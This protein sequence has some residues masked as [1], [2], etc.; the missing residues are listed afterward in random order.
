VEYPVAVA[1]AESV[2]HLPR[3]T[4]WW[5]EPKFD[6]DRGVLW[7]RDTVRIQTRAGRDATEQWYDIAAAA[8]TLPP[9]TV[10]DGELVIWRDGRIDFGAVRSRASARG[11]RLTDLIQRQPATYAAFDCLMLGGRDL[12]G[13]SYLDRRAA[14]LEVLDPLGPPLQA[15]PATD[16]IDV[17][18]AWHEHLPAQGIEG[19]VAKAATGTYRPTRDWKKIRHA[20]TVDAEVIGYVGPAERPRRAAVLL[21]DGRRVLSQALPPPIVNEVA[22]L[23]ADSGPGRRARTDDGET[24]T[25]TGQGLVVEVESGTTRHATVAVVRVR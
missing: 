5:Y 16:D 11:R 21:P 7:R 18:L 24:Y 14:L 17:A 20:E 12:R 22:R 6:G 2:S 8:M 13:R 3:G 19:T 15:V 25:T 1:L 10:L 4:G 9:D 23:I